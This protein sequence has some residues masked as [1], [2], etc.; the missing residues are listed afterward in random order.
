MQRLSRGRRYLADGVT[1]LV[2][3]SLRGARPRRD[4]VA[5]VLASIAAIVIP[6]RVDASPLN[7]KGS[8]MMKLAIAGSALVAAG[9]TA[10]LVHDRSSAI[11]APVSAQPAARALHYGAGVPRKPALGPAS[12]VHPNTART[13]SVDDLSLL[14]P[15]AELVIGA[16]V[17]R[18]QSS[19]IW[20][21]FVA[22][23]LA[24]AP[25]L[26]ELTTDCGFDPVASLS[27]IT[28]GLKNMGDDKD[29]AGTVVLHGFPKAKLFPCISKL[30]AKEGN[31]S[32]L[33]VEGGVML[34]GGDDHIA[35]TFLDDTTALVVIGPD[36]TKDGIATIST[37]RNQPDSSAYAELIHE[38]NTD[39]ALWLAVNDSSPVLA[40]INRK[41]ASK[42]SIQ[43][44]GLYGSIDLTDGIVLNAGG[45][46]GSPELVAKLVADVQRHLDQLGSREQIAQ[47]FE[48]LDINADG[49][50]VIVSVA[51]NTSQLVQ[52]FAGDFSVKIE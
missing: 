45:R 44:H 22:P 21:L 48:Q 2:E 7:S 28:I 16:D 50:D 27:S 6:S 32:G 39:D 51:I 1:A 36:A 34:S 5:A 46:T 23:A 49:G 13:V 8:T 18:I 52:M 29:V 25:G 35:L 41:I 14:P 43:F 19:T 12:P 10:Y 4:L 33:H 9:A 11:P 40:E 17:A 3:S 24:N 26:H 30:D 37:R 31:K 20:K 15:D 47:H 38:I 42:T